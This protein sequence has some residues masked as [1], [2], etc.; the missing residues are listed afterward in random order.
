MTAG[1]SSSSQIDPA[2]ITTTGVTQGAPSVT[3]NA[4]AGSTG[5]RDPGSRQTP[6]ESAGKVTPADSLRPFSTVVGRTHHRSHGA[7]TTPRQPGERSRNTNPWPPPAV[8]DA[9][10]ERDSSVASLFGGE[11]PSSPASVSVIGWPVVVRSVAARRMRAM[12]RR[13]SSS[14]A[15]PP[16][17]SEPGSWTHGARGPA[18]GE[19]SPPGGAG[20]P[21]LLIVVMAIVLIPVCWFTFVTE[22]SGHLQCPEAHRLERPG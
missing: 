9:S 12:D 22:A 4:A 11:Q 21:N 1:A 7:T 14:S 20:A 13:H 18:G 15:D 2:G 17:Q 10:L 5:S 6:P 16:A 8:T 3:Q 19:P